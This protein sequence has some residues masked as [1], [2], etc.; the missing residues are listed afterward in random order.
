[1][2][3]NEYADITPIQGKQ[4]A[5]VHKII[6]ENPAPHRTEDGWQVWNF[7]DREESNEPIRILERPERQF[8]RR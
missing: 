8:P 6:N 3:Q 1:M 7:E 2:K 5:L 4:I